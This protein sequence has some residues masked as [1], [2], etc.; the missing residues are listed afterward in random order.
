MLTSILHK[1]VSDGMISLVIPVYNEEEII[2]ALYERCTGILE[3]H[4]GDFE[5]ICVD[6]GSTDRTLERLISYHER[7]KRFKVISLSRNFGH[8]AALLA[9]LSHARGD[10]IAM[11]DGDLQDPPEM[12]PEF[13]DK[14]KEG[15]DV[16]YG[17]RGKRKEGILKKLL[18][19][20][21]YRLLGSISNVH[22]PFDSGDFSMVTRRVLDVILQTQE[23]SL[24]LRGT[25]AWV[26]FRQTGIE[27]ERNARISGTPKYTLKKLFLLAYNGLFSFSNFPIKILAR[28]G[29][30]VLIFSVSYTIYILTKK[31]FIG[32]V[33][34]G[35]TTL[36]LVLFFFNGILLIAI[37]IIGEYIIRIYDEIRK[38]PLFIVRD[39]FL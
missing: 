1:R 31:F 30:V 26:G 13:Y 27:Y 3:K 29:L 36:I 39:K 9:G 18:Y 5:I 19:W 10:Y 33:P 15:Y 24:F 2:P 11:L 21:F 20:G 14:I 37:G 28:L 35:F 34:Q 7:D 16:V 22:I 8:Q 12:L 32:G 25:R 17:I 6:D 23:H 4:F 38:K